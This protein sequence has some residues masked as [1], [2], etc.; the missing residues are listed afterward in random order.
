[1]GSSREHG[2][3]RLEQSGYKERMAGEFNRAN[4]PPTGQQ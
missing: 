3:L 2:A 1:V 4:R